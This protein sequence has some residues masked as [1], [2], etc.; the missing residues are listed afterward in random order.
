MTD[1][2]ELTNDQKEDIETILKRIRAGLRRTDQLPLEEPAHLFKP[3][4]VHDKK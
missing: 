2:P 4:I 3:G 1:R